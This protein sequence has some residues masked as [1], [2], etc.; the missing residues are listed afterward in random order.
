[1]TINESY[2][3]QV[4]LLIRCLPAVSRVRA[5]AL[6]GGTAINLFHRDMPRLSVDIDLTFLAMTDRDTAMAG[7]VEGLAK[8]TEEIQR[9]IPDSRVLSTGTPTPKLQI[10][11]PHARIKVEPNPIF[12]GC[13]YPPI[14]RDLCQSAQDQYELFARVHCLATGDLFGSKL[15]AALD[16]Q[17]PRD[18]FDVKQLLD[19]GEICK[20]IRQ[21]F[22]VYLAGHHRPIAEL[23]APN[24]KPLKQI[25]ANHFAGMTAKSITL[26]ELEAVREQLFTWT[27]TALQENE[28]KF[29]LSLKQGDPDWSLMPFEHI[30]QLP[31]IQWKLHNIKRM[32]APA[33]A[34]A[35]ERL[36]VV[37]DL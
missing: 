33:H 22:V 31:A 2:R 28:R 11:T 13:L 7:I 21:A 34:T 15:C 6:K 16:R 4:D 37:L 17:H 12:R 18:L 32:Q 30:R 29:L 8:I 36:R 20:D 5:F 27:L 25:Y 3:A 23:L 26:N 10:A 1:M 35:V 9:T 24:T 19:S 14:E